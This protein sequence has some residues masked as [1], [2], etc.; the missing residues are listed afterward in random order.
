MFVSLIMVP[1]VVISELGGLGASIDALDNINP[2]LFDAFMDAS[3]N[4]ALTVIGI[5]SLMS[6]GLGRQGQIGRAHV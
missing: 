4:E 5:I 6:W 2:A 1:A 3:S